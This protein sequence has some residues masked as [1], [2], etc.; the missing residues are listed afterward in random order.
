[1]FSSS[2]ARVR[3]DEAAR[4]A[5]AA[6]HQHGGLRLRNEALQRAPALLSNR[7]TTATSGSSATPYC[8]SARS[9]L[10]HADRRNRAS[11]AGGYELGVIKP[12]REVD[13]VDL[14]IEAHLFQHPE[15]AK[16]SGRGCP[17]DRDH[18]TSA[19]PGM[20][21]PVPPGSCSQQCPYSI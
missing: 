5:R 12:S 10:H 18:V 7:L 11:R 2:M 3:P 16:R 1:M 6:G 14:I 9:H 8:E 15:D 19:W 20:T 13:R 4:R 17:V 21:R